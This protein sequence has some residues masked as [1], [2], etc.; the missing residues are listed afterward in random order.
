MIRRDQAI[1]IPIK[2]IEEQFYSSFDEVLINCLGVFI[3]IRLGD[4]WKLMTDFT[5]GSSLVIF[6]KQ[7]SNREVLFIS[8]NLWRSSYFRGKWTVF[9]LYNTFKLFLLLV[10]FVFFQSLHESISDLKSWFLIDHRFV[11]ELFC[12]LYSLLLFS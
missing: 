2:E 5:F 10:L 8:G 9:I 1:F 11:G 12:L 3:F 6:R 7:I 4:G